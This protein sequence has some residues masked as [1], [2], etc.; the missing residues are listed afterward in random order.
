MQLTDTSNHICFVR[1]ALALDE[2]RVKFLPEYVAV[3]EPGTPS[4]EVQVPS[5]ESS[6]ALSLSVTRPA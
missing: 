5:G 1:H 4:G 2:R 6:V 3:E